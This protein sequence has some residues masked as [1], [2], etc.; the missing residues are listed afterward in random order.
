MKKIFNLIF[1]AVLALGLISCQKSLLNSDDNTGFGDLII[2]NL[3]LDSSF[4][5]KELSSEDKITVKVGD[6]TK[7]LNKSTLNTPI[8][9]KPATYSINVE[10][11]VKKTHGKYVLKGS[12]DATITHNRVA[13]IKLFS[14]NE[15]KGYG[16]LKINKKINL[17]TDIFSD[18]SDDDLNFEKAVLKIDNTAEKFDTEK[19]FEAKEVKILIEVP[20]KAGTYLYYY[21]TSKTITAGEISEISS[22]KLNKKKLPIKF[23]LTL[24]KTLFE[25]IK[26]NEK[27]DW[28]NLNYDSL[29]NLV[30]RGQH[31]SWDGNDFKLNKEGEVWTNTFEGFEYG[32]RMKII[33]DD[34]W[35]EYNLLVTK[36]LENGKVEIMLTESAY[37]NGLKSNDI[38][39]NNLTEVH[40]TGIN[41]WNADDKTYSL[42]KNPENGIWSGEFDFKEGT[43]FKFIISSSTKSDQWTSEDN[44]I[45]I[46]FKVVK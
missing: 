3:S 35:S 38:D 19:D 27:N 24:N 13:A 21:E 31:N 46:D 28:D 40:L 4:V 20:N 41:N 17:D 34:K 10:V 26:A 25:K 44:F 22:V 6:T 32:Q 39:Y 1:V 11:E 29:T 43:I 42:T 36:R 8:I 37:N 5:T 2:E 45:L 16:S 23:N 33:A 14:L 12:K 7:E 30:L 18:M 9:V 15:E